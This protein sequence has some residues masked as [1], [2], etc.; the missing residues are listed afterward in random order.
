MHFSNS[1]FSKVSSWGMTTRNDHKCTFFNNQSTILNQIQGSVGIPFGAGRSYGDVCLNS[2]SS[3]WLTAR[4]N[5]FIAFDKNEGIIKVE[6]GVLLKEIQEVAYK[7]GWAISV[8]PGTQFVS[9]GGALAND[10]HGKNH[11]RFGSFGNH[12]LS[13]RLLKT[14][15]EIL[16]CSEIFNKELFFATIGGFGLTGIILDVSIKLRRVQST[17]L[18]VENTLFQSLSE[19]FF[20]SDNSEENWEYNVAWIDCL[21]KNNRGIFMAANWTKCEKAKKTNLKTRNIPFTP[22]FSVINKFTVKLFNSFFYNSKRLVSN[23]KIIDHRDYLFPL[24]NIQNWNRIYGPHGFYQ[25]QCLIPKKERLLVTKEILT[26]ISRYG[27]GSFLAVLKNFGSIKS[28]GLMSFPGEGVTF[29]LDFPNKQESTKKL[30]KR[31]DSIIKSCAGRIYIAKDALMDPEL[32]R[33]SY[34]NLESFL[35]HRDP[36]ISSD[37][38]RRLIGY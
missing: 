28:R 2:N 32:F 31:L 20:I 5:K 33:L 24:D 35:K 38:S 25:Y 15:G 1:G 14:N 18:E 8:T 26:Q 17:Y 21:A 37:L 30:F 13:F 34:Q 23:T 11:H 19:F 6:S 16:E 4:L 12:I 3:L 36:G 27:E 7:A 29:S 10:V 22:P 9:V